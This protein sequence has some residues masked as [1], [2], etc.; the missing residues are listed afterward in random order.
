MNTPEV[1][2][3]FCWIKKYVKL[4]KSRLVVSPNILFKITFPFIMPSDFI[5]YLYIL[6]VQKVLN[7]KEGI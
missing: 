7:K 3:N 2:L 6:G 1:S 4:G 5:Y